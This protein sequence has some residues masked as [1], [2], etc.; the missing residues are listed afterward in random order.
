[1]LPLALL[2]ACGPDGPT[3]DLTALPRGVR[4][5]DAQTALLLREAR[6][7]EI[8]TVAPAWTHWRDVALPA[9]ARIERSLSARLADGAT[10]KALAGVFDEADRAVVAHGA[11]ALLAADVSPLLQQAARFTADRL[12]HWETLAREGRV[13]DLAAALA[14]AQARPPQAV[15]GV[16]S[17]PLQPIGTV[18]WAESEGSATPLV[19]LEESALIGPQPGE[20]Q[21]ASVAAPTARIRALQA[22]LGHDPIVLL[23]WVRTNLQPVIG[24]GMERSLDRILDSGVGTSAELSAVLLSLL[25]AADVPARFL[26]YGPSD[27]FGYLGWPRA[28]ERVVVEAF[29]PMLGWRGYTVEPADGQWAVLDPYGPDAVTQPS[30]PGPLAERAGAWPS[31][32]VDDFLRS[33]PASGNWPTWLSESPRAAMFPPFPAAATG[34][35]L[36]STSALPFLVNA[37]HESSPNVARRFVHAGLDL[38]ESLTGRIDLELRDGGRVI[39]RRDLQLARVGGHRL[40]LTFVPSDVEAQIAWAEAGGVLGAPC[41]TLAMR[42]EL[43]LD[44]LVHS[45]GSE[46]VALCAPVELYVRGRTGDDL[47]QVS[48]QLWVGESLV[49]QAGASRASTA[50]T[51]PVTMD[52]EAG[53]VQALFVLAHAYSRD[54]ATA[55]ARLAAWYGLQS[56]QPL[57]DVIAAGVALQPRQ[58]LGQPTMLRFEGLNLDVWRHVDGTAGF[59]DEAERRSYEALR[60]VVSSELEAEVFESQL[61]LSAVSTT[62]VLRQAAQNGI[63]PVTATTATLAADMPPEVR[64]AVQSALAMGYDVRMVTAPTRI[65]SVDAWGWIV[66]DAFSGRA[67]YYLSGGLAGGRTVEDPV[68]WPLEFWVPGMVRTTVDPDSALS[69]Q[70]HGL[71]TPAVMAAGSQWPLRVVVQGTAGRMVSFLPLRIAATDGAQVSHDGETWA[72]EV[73]VE[74]DM[75]GSAR[76]HFQ[77]RLRLPDRPLLWRREG[78]LPVPVGPQQLVVR[79][80]SSEQSR[81]LAR[82]TSA[83]HPGEPH[84]IV[85]ERAASALQGW[86]L[87]VDALDSA[88]AEVSGIPASSFP[89]QFWPAAGPGEVQDA[90]MTYRVVDAHGNGVPGVTL[91]L[92]SADLLVLERADSGLGVTLRAVSPSTWDEA[93]GEPGAGA[94]PDLVLPAPGCFGILSAADLPPSCRAPLSSPVALSTG[95]DG[96]VSTRILASSRWPRPNVLE[97]HGGWSGLPAS[98]LRDWV[99]MGTKVRVQ[100]VVTHL[101]ARATS[102]D[103][104]RVGLAPGAAALDLAAGRQRIDMAGTADRRGY[105]SLPE[106]LDPLVH[107]TRRGHLLADVIHPVGANGRVV[108]GYDASRLPAPLAQEARF[109][110]RTLMVENGQRTYRSL[111]VGAEGLTAELAFVPPGE[112][113]EAVLNI[114]TWLASARLSEGAGLPAAPLR[115]PWRPEVLM[116]HTRSDAVLR[117]QPRGGTSGVQ[118]LHYVWRYAGDPSTSWCAYDAPWRAVY[119]EGTGPDPV[120]RQDLATGVWASTC[121]VGSGDTWT[122]VS[123]WPRSCFDGTAGYRHQLAQVMG[124]PQDYAEIPAVTL[125]AAQGAPADWQWQPGAAAGTVVNAQAATLSWTWEP[126]GWIPAE[127]AVE[128]LTPCASGQ[129]VSRRFEPTREG[130][131]ATWR[132]DAWGLELAMEKYTARLVLNGSYGGHRVES[133]GVAVYAPIVLDVLR[134]AGSGSLEIVSEGVDQFVLKWPSEGLTALE[135]YRPRVVAEPT[136]RTWTMTLRRNNWQATAG[137][138]CAAGSDIVET[139]T[140]AVDPAGIFAVSRQPGQ[141]PAYTTGCDKGGSGGKKRSNSPWRMTVRGERPGVEPVEQV[142]EQDMRGIVVQEY[143]DHYPYLGPNGAWIECLKAGDIA[144]SPR[145]PRCGQGNFRAMPSVTDIVPAVFTDTYAKTGDS[146]CDFSCPIMISGNYVG[147]ELTY[148]GSGFT[149]VEDVNQEWLSQMAAWYPDHPVEPGWNIVRVDYVSWVQSIWR[150]PER[151]ESTSIVMNSDHQFGSGVDFSH[152]DAFEDQIRPV[153]EFN[154]DGTVNDRTSTAICL[155]AAAAWESG[156]TKQ[157]LVENIRSGAG[158]PIFYTWGNSADVAGCISAVNQKV[159]A[160]IALKT[161]V[162]NLASAPIVVRNDCTPTHVHSARPN[163]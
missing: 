154:D 3:A 148:K 38:P 90:L 155:L 59:R 119:G 149:F 14:T 146:P 91:T 49:L 82:Q 121:G 48:R 159:L 37:L 62:R 163:D 15:L 58:V 132:V 112:S 68:T 41:G 109:M 150:N 29:V 130:N 39:W 47:W 106:T 153:F 53:G 54:L 30:R 89:S 6:R 105:P 22:D 126:A 107:M 2:S 83:A 43:R 100:R 143:W 52:T 51:V 141:P 56:A 19:G 99:M 97:D 103:P 98:S 147:A 127:M 151:Q 135:H 94:G 81:E 133:E 145:P 117:W 111:P 17:L 142:F 79:T 101:D 95:D 87:A 140:A 1:L 16:R 84:A 20:S 44:G 55:E 144:S 65:G 160:C 122:P 32:L 40:S 11:E 46:P 76:V 26:I 75:L 113:P 134:D 128:L 73:V 123:D 77:A 72:D 9:A 158:G 93:T 31:T 74:T 152:K 131:T 161:G 115:I 71:P 78:A 139:G 34:S 50:P 96:R 124:Y 57:V 120:C 10:A 85:V 70:I 66:E 136:P 114:S 129:C 12:T 110:L 4:L 162:Q 156:G 35:P 88:G 108:V 69:A 27:R 64:E 125:S 92:T 157:T 33:P 138:N 8:V 118:Q 18:E 13:A 63:L 5:S 86:P 116:P 67:G 36:L 80:E 21:T 60:G 137:G 102:W 104:G 45:S 28:P 23:N 7:R 24:W 42:P 61:G 25:W